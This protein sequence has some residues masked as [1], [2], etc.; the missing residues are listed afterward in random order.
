MQSMEIILST[1]LE[2]IFCFNLNSESLPRQNHKDFFLNYFDS[3][4]E[5]N[6][7]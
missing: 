2:N 4:F 1:F 3:H 6:K 7:I 5:S